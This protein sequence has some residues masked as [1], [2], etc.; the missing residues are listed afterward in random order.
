MATVSAIVDLWISARH[1]I[2]V[3]ERELDAR[4][5]ESVGIP[6]TTYA[7]LCTIAELGESGIEISQQH[8]AH[9]LAIDKSNVSRH[10][11]AAVTSGHVSSAPSPTSRRSKSVE[12]TAKGRASLDAAEALVAEFAQG[13]DLRSIAETTRILGAI[14]DAVES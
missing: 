14:G 2:A 13:L 10:I 12:L 5:A 9:A 11:E 1:A 8:I 6:F 7:V 3:V 4:L